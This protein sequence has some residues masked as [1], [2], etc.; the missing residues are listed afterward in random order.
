MVEGVRVVQLEEVPGVQEGQQEPEAL[1]H[2]RVE[3]VDG[4]VHVAVS[5]AERLEPVE[6]ASLVGEL[7]V[8]EEGH[9]NVEEHQ[10][11]SEE[12]EALPVGP[13]E[14]DSAGEGRD[15]MVGAPPAL[16]T[17]TVDL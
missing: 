3:A 17:R 14:E 12:T 4:D 15:K 6:T 8:L 1:P 16:D 7:E 2:P 9:V 5:L 10:L 13:D 11:G